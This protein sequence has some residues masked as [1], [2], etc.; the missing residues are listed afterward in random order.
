MRDD[1]KD[2]VLIS[3]DE[4]GFIL[5]A[6]LNSLENNDTINTSIGLVLAI[7]RVD[8]MKAKLEGKCNQ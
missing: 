8:E 4:V 7:R 6:A 3:L 5:K 1:E 2:M